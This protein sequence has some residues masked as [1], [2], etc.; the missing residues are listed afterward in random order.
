MNSPF[1]LEQSEA[2]IQELKFAEG[3][4]REERITAIFE[5][6]VHRPPDQLDF[7]RIGRFVDIEKERKQHAWPLVAQALFMSNEFLYID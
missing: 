5:T 3:T 1:V 4:S 7:D 2:L 6:I